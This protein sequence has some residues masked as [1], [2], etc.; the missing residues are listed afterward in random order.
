[1]TGFTP[2]AHIVWS[3]MKEMSSFQRCLLDIFH[4][5][6]QKSGVDAGSKKVFVNDMSST[7]LLLWY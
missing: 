5:Y 7:K 3:S 1:M 6:E 2:D 4:A